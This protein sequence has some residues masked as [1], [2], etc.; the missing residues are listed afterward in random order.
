[1][2][3][4][5]PESVKN[6]QIFTNSQSPSI[7]VDASFGFVDCDASEQLKSQYIPYAVAP[8]SLWQPANFYYETAPSAARHD[9]RSI[10]IFQ[11][12]EELLAYLRWV[13][14]TSVT[15]ADVVA[16]IST[17]EGRVND[18]FGS[19]NLAVPHMKLRGFFENPADRVT[20]TW[21]VSSSRY[22]GLHLDSFEGSGHDARRT[23]PPRASLNIG[24]GHRY[25]LVCDA[26]TEE[27][28]EYSRQCQTQSLPLNHQIKQFLCN[29][30]GNFVLRFRLAP[31]FGYVASTENI[32]HEGSNAGSTEVDKT[33]VFFSPSAIKAASE[34]A[35]R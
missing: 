2:Y 16:A 18:F 35:T 29:A 21:D 20:L 31:G 24:S 17:I 22:V 23:R 34:V 27:V 19:L 5:R 6:I 30:H 15:D 12:D 9:G 4:L 7:A 8:S 26:T 14:D 28:L 13:L 3:Q 11:F 32:I 25:L 10:T 33:V 1:M